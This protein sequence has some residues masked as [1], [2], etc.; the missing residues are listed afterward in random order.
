MTLLEIF[1]PLALAGSS[2]QG[3]PPATAWPSPG[4]SP[5]ATTTVPA[6]VAATDVPTL[7]PT[8]TEPPTATSTVGIPTQV[9]TFTATASP[10]P[11]KQPP[12]N[13]RAWTL[14]SGLRIALHVVYVNPFPVGAYIYQ[15]SVEV[16][17]AAGTVL[18]LDDNSRQAGLPVPGGTRY[19][20]TVEESL[21]KLPEGAVAFRLPD[22]GMVRIEPVSAELQP[23]FAATPAVHV[24]RDEIERDGQD[25]RHRMRAKR[26]DGLSGTVTVTALHFDGRDAFLYCT[27]GG[28]PMEPNVWSDFTLVTSVDLRYSKRHDVF[29][30]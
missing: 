28:A 11:V 12:A 10:P 2:L 16:V 23:R 18:K 29:F 9:P 13:L 22:A 8:T 3:S 30:R 26:M 27:R 24:E 6:T 20:F 15:P 17:D 4:P 21:S 1:L 5:S 7:A 25:Y 14:D 19:C